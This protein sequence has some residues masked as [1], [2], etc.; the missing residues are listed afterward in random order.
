MTYRLAQE[1]ICLVMVF[2]PIGLV[3]TPAHVN[4]LLEHSPH[5]RLRRVP[6]AAL[7]RDVVLHTRSCV[8]FEFPRIDRSA[9]ARIE[10]LR[11]V[12]VSFR[13]VNVLGGEVDAKALNGDFELSGGIT[14]GHEAE[15][16][17]Q[18]DD[19]L[20]VQ[21]K[22]YHFGTCLDALVAVVCRDLQYRPPCENISMSLY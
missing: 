3:V 12:G 8:N 19:S 5:E 21:C 9:E 10:G 7:I 15:D 13:V 22:W 6:P 1:S 20:G 2:L 4:A 11:V 17:D 18:V 16:H 14:V